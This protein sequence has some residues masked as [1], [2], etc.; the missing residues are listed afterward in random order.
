MLPITYFLLPLMLA[1]VTLAN[2]YRYNQASNPGQQNRA[3]QFRNSGFNQFKRVTAGVS[4]FMADK[5]AKSD[6]AQKSSIQKRVF[7]D[8]KGD[9]KQYVQASYLDPAIASF[10]PI[11]DA[12]VDKH[13]RKFQSVRVD[14]R[15]HTQEAIKQRE[16]DFAEWLSKKIDAKF[17]NYLGGKFQEWKRGHSILK[18]RST[19]V[20]AAGLQKRFVENTPKNHAIFMIVTSFLFLPVFMNPFAAGLWGILVGLGLAVVVMPAIMRKIVF[21]YWSWF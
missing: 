5:I 11:M 1:T 8:L 10:Q 18:K 7:A 3:N 13:L 17:K 2:N 20:S 12:E 16:K 14:P 15:K 21:G 19:E 9:I 6:V 4:E